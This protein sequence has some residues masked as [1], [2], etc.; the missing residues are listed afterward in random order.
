MESKLYERL[1]SDFIEEG[2]T[3][4]TLFT[5]LSSELG[6]VMSERVNETRKKINCTTEILDELS[7][8]LWYIAAIA[9]TRGSSLGELMIHN[10]YKL[11]KR[12]ING[13]EVKS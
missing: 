2:T 9:K 3:E 1:I 12:K 11:E 8:V 7:D 13:K 10:Y 4:E 6:E 5:G